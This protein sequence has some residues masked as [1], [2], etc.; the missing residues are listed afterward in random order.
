MLRFG[1]RVQ[2]SG[3]KQ[4]RSHCVG[5]RV[6]GARIYVLLA[7]P[8]SMKVAQVLLSKIDI[9]SV[10]YVDGI[11]ES[12]GACRVALF[13]Y[14]PFY[15]THVVF[16]HIPSVVVSKREGFPNHRNLKLITVGSTGTTGASVSISGSK[17]KDMNNF[18][19][20]ADFLAAVNIIYKEATN[21]TK[22]PKVVVRS[23][24]TPNSVDIITVMLTEACELAGIS[25]VGVRSTSLY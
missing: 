20:T 24:N 5:I 10:Q 14:C 8:A 4:D 25:A 22:Q 19:R 9:R 21:G 3:K 23:D 7:P 18:M 15:D 16:P 1:D 17:V 13:K 12:I 11:D 2:I 6:A